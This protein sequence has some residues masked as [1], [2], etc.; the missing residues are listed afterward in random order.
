MTISPIKLTQIGLNKTVELPFDKIGNVK[1]EWF[2]LG[3][4]CVGTLYKNQNHDND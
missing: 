1:G 2:D 4:F 3:N